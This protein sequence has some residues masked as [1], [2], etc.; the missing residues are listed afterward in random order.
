MRGAASRLERQALRI[1]R[2]REAG[3]AGTQ[4]FDEVDVILDD[5]AREEQVELRVL[6]DVAELSVRKRVLT[7]TTIAP[8]SWAPKKA[9]TKS[10]Q[11]GIS[12]PTW[13]PRPMP[14]AASDRAARSERSVS[15]R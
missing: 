7:G 6:D 1:G 4:A 10:G 11:F 2:L 14:R 15:S 9:N 5:V 13:S 8:S 3:Q 12:S